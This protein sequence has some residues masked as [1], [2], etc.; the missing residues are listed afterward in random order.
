MAQILKRTLYRIATKSTSQ[1]IKLVVRKFT[2]FLSRY[3]KQILHSLAKCIRTTLLI[4]YI[5]KVIRKFAKMTT[6]IFHIAEL[7]FLL[8]SFPISNIYGLSSE[9]HL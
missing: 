9:G 5:Q 3:K 1:W 2:N 8:A 4:P 6:L 7:H